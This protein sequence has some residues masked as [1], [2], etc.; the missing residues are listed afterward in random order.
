MLIVLSFSSSFRSISHEQT[1]VEKHISLNEER[2]AYF[3]N[4]SWVKPR[5]RRGIKR[6]GRKMVKFEGCGGAAVRAKFRIGGRCMCVCLF[7]W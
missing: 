1:C 6:N 5:S 3:R 2:I 4:W 7:D